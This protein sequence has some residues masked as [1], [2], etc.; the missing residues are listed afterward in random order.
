MFKEEDYDE[1]VANKV[2][3]ARQDY[4]AGRFYSLAEAKKLSEQALEKKA[5]ELAE[6]ER[7]S[8]V[9]YG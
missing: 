7:E 5:L 8:R 2:A 1:Y 4:Q 6:F 3:E 9:I